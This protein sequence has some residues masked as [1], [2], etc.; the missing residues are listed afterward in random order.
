[1]SRN[2]Q[3]YVWDEALPELIEDVDFSR[4]TPEQWDAISDAL[5]EHVSASREYMAPVPSGR[6]I[7]EMEFRPKRDAMQEEIDRLKFE[8]R[9]YDKHLTHGSQFLYTTVDDHGYVEVRQMRR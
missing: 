3:G 9:A 5:N 4:V 6:E 1:M 2:E 7:A 8:V